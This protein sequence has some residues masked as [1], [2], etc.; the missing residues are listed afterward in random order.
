MGSG[1]GEPAQAIDQRGELIGGGGEPSRRTQ[2]S[3]ICYGFKI[4][5]SAVPIEV[6][7]LVAGPIAIGAT[8]TID[9]PCPLLSGVPG[10][11][12]QPSWN[13]IIIG[14]LGVSQ[15]LGEPA[16][17][18]NLD[19][20]VIKAELGHDVP[21]SPSVL[22]GLVRPLRLGWA[23]AV[24]GEEDEEVVDRDTAVVVEVGRDGD[25]ALLVDRVPDC[26]FPA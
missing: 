23:G 11:P 3:G 16:L 6:L 10:D 25:D 24:D 13:V 17:I 2:P 14:V 12:I 4:V 15:I 21:A 5:E 19:C 22:G 9:A 26:A 20:R 8:F 1:C 18:P 7:H